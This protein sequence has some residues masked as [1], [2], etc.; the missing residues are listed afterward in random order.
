MTKPYIVFFVTNIFEERTVPDDIV[1][2]ETVTNT[3]H[4]VFQHVVVYVELV[5]D[6]VKVEDNA[7]YT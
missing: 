2:V 1:I 7:D 6:K 5:H 4:R 3:R